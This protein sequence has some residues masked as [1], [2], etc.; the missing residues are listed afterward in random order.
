MH[1]QSD[2]VGEAS[3]R[4]LA[5]HATQDESQAHTRHTGE[6]QGRSAE[7]QHCHQPGGE[8][9]GPAHYP[10]GVE[11]AGDCHPRPQGVTRVPDQ[12]VFF[13]F[14]AQVKKNQGPG[15]QQNVKEEAGDEEGAGGLPGGG[16]HEQE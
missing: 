8:E 15:G 7:H 5:T 2:L 16:Q 1:A 11:H 6:Y 10:S 9:K 4:R 12:I 3:H 14:P 13:D